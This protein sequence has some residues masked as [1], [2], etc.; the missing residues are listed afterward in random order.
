MQTISPSHFSAFYKLPMILSYEVTTYVESSL[1]HPTYLD[2]QFSH[3][4]YRSGL[5]TSHWHSVKMDN[6]CSWNIAKT[7]VDMEG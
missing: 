6:L 3:R 5:S 2:S 4:I 1:P 7:F